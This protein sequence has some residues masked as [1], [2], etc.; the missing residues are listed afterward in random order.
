M[1][2]KGILLHGTG[3]RET[4]RTWILRFPC[5]E[6]DERLLLE[7]NR[8]WNFWS[9]ETLEPILA[10]YK[11]GSS[12]TATAARANLQGAVKFVSCSL[13]PVP[14]SEGRS[15]RGQGHET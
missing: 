12:G 6:I 14:S 1:T 10:Q 13:S 4:D 9:K 2:D 8:L 7:R 5:W 11:E 3:K 15:A